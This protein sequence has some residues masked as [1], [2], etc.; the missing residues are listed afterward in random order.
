MTTCVSLSSTWPPTREHGGVRELSV[1][2]RGAERCPHVPSPSQRLLIG[3][4]AALSLRANATNAGEGAFEAEL[5]VQLPPGTH[6]QAAR[7]SIPV[8]ARG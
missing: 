6:Y 2:P 1:S 5:R 3:A 4:E 7:S 8:R